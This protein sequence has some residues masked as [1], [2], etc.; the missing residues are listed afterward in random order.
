M[1]HYP[2]L[3]AGLLLATTLT[4]GYGTAM[5]Q[6]GTGDA[7]ARDPNVVNSQQPESGPQ[8]NRSP[9]DETDGET[10]TSP[11][12]DALA[13]LRSAPPDLQGN[14]MARPNQYAS[15]PGQGRERTR[16]QD[17]SDLSRDSHGTLPQ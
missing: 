14:P 11:L 2:K 7:L 16:S 5:A 4:F 13:R 1:R 17:P 9:S 12:Q 8:G 10:S 6:T 15:E 3:V